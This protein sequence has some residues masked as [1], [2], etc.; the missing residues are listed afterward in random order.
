MYQS[1]SAH[2]STIA[3]L[4]KE[5]K[6]GDALELQNIVLQKVKKSESCD[7]DILRDDV[8]DEGFSSSEM[9]VMSMMT[10]MQANALDDD[11]VAVDNDDPDDMVHFVNT[12]KAV[13]ITMQL[14]MIPITITF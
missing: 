6:K 9:A 14:H 7:D 8:D 3:E 4:Q 10:V 2:N 13:S 5:K 1:I 11:F 12:T